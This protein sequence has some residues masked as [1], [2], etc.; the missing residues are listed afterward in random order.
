MS[1]ADLKVMVNSKLPG[2][3]DF[4]TI[5]EQIA[6]L[7]LEL[8][9]YIDQKNE[10]AKDR[11]YYDKIFDYGRHR[12]GSIQRGMDNGWRSYMQGDHNQFPMD[13]FSKKG[14]LDF[15]IQLRV[16]TH[17]AYSSFSNYATPYFFR[18]EDEERM[19]YIGMALVSSSINYYAASKVRV[20]QSGQIVKTELSDAKNAKKACQ[21]NSRLD[22]F[23]FSTG[24]DI[25]IME[26]NLNNHQ[27]EQTYSHIFAGETV[28]YMTSGGKFVFT[29]TDKGLYAIKR[30]NSHSYQRYTA[31]EMGVDITNK[32]VMCRSTKDGKTLV[33]VNGL[34]YSQHTANRLD[35]YHWNGAKYVKQEIDTTNR[36]NIYNQFPLNSSFTEQRIALSEDGKMAVVVDSASSEGV[37]NVIRQREDGNYQY[38]LLSKETDIF[39]RSFFYEYVN[40]PRERTGWALHSKGQWLIGFS[41]EASPAYNLALYA[42][43]LLEEGVPVGLVGRVFLGAT[44]D[45]DLRKRLDRLV[46]VTFVGDRLRIDRVDSDQTLLAPLIIELPKRR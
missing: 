33:V 40:S 34:N 46:G 28:Q 13:I 36:K 5:D 2:Q 26:I 25:R 7:R 27:Y 45:S 21:G 42:F 10:E 41:F 43:C 3:E 37:L 8:M 24:S 30:N 44:T 17:N 18:D 15:G 9:N 32:P 39:C 29:I 31:L 38:D 14:Y 1:I 19:V 20:P 23:A 6:A 35:I 11:E 22:F 16:G 12:D 4:K